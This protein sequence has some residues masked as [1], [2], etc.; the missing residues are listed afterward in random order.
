MVGCWNNIY[1]TGGFLLGGLNAKKWGEHWKNFL[2]N[3][4]VWLSIGFCHKTANYTSFADSWSTSEFCKNLDTVGPNQ[5]LTANADSTFA[6]QME[7]YKNSGLIVI[8]HCLNS[9]QHNNYV[10]FSLLYV[11]LREN[12]K[13]NAAYFTSFHNGCNPTCQLWSRPHYTVCFIS[14]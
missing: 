14:F 6:Y 9:F 5:L 4:S 12:C 7:E 13:I 3:N 2:I 1:L 11:L 10:A 8:L